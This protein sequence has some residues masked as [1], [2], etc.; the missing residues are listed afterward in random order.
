MMARRETMEAT[1]TVTGCCYEGCA[2]KA[3]VVDDDGDWC[4]AKCYAQSHRYVVVSDL[5]EEN[6][7]STEQ[8]ERV[9]AI[10][11]ADGWDVEIRKPRRGE[12]VATYYRKRDGTLQIL[13]YS[14]PVPEAFS[15]AEQ[16]A[17]NSVI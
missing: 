10:M 13:G 2:R 17:I 5:D 4:C 15:E 14:I 3:T 7:I 11:T 16:D 12:A 9:V 1:T 6:D 8:A